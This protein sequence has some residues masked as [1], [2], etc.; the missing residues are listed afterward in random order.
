M[1]KVVCFLVLIF[2]GEMANAQSKNTN[3][4]LEIQQSLAEFIAKEKFSDKETTIGLSDIS[5][6]PELIFKL[7]QAA[8]DFQRITRSN[9]ASQA[10]L[11]E[12]LGE[13]LD[14]FKDVY[15]KLD[16]EDR[17]LIGNYFEELMD[18]VGLESS[19]GQLNNFV[20]GL[21]NFNLKN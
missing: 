11:L 19:D 5:M 2:V 15:L 17:E 14:R 18:I 12:V 13:G 9:N 4:L 21:G 8:K 20:Y 1:K 10:D 16:T 6:R 3:E 7:N